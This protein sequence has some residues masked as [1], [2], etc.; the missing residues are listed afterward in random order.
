MIAETFY[1]NLTGFKKRYYDSP[2]VI[3]RTVTYGQILSIRAEHRVLNAG[4]VGLGNAENQI[5]L[6]DSTIGPAYDYA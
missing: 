4:V 5:P 6:A 3:S 1:I 2:T